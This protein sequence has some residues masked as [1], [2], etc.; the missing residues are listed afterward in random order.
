MK[1][2]SIF[3]LGSLLTGL[4][5]FSCDDK[6]EKGEDSTSQSSLTGSFLEN[7]GCKNSNDLRS[8]T[9]DSVSYDVKYKFDM[10]A[11][12]GT[13]THVNAYYSCEVE[14]LTTQ[15]RINKDSIFIKE[16]G[17]GGELVDC[18]CPYDITTQFSGIEEKVYHV[19]IDLGASIDFYNFDIDLSKQAEGYWSSN[20]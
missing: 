14:E 4:C 16:I 1:R 9:N 5:L 15:V 17:K 7:S 8:A 11:G 3:I 2:I 10:K 19:Q 13:I 12:K 6:D 20:Q 18:V